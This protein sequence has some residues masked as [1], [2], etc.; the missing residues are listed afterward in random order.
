MLTLTLAWRNLFR[1]GRRTLLTVLLIGCSLAAM[2]MT[3]A[4]IIGMSNVLVDSV[5]HTLLGEAQVDRKG[6]RTS[7]DSSLYLN[8]ASHIEQV[9]A[10]SP[11][12]AAWA[13]RVITGGMVSSSY[14]IASGMIYGV[15]ARKELAVSRIKN[16]IVKGKYLS[17]KPGQILL[18][19][20]L[21]RQLEV[22]LGD[23]IVLTVSQ[24]E[25]GDLS[26]ALFR[27]SGLVHF[28]TREFDDHFVFINL[29]KARDIL[30]MHD[31]LQ[32]IAIQ[33]KRAADA[34]N[35]NLPLF[36]KLNHGDVEAV[37]WLEIN[38]GIASVLGWT[39]YSSAIVAVVL[40]LL[41]SFGV[42]N[43]MFMSI[44]ERIYEIGVIKSIGTRPWQILQLILTEAALLALLGAAFGVALGWG[45]GSWFS[46]H[47]IPFGEYELSG[48]M[49]SNNIRPVLKPYQF[50]DFPLYVIL[51]TI[52]AAIYPAR[53]A[54]KIVPAEALQRSL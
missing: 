46:I 29:A 22:K 14:N 19:D 30:G 42:I 28:G 13:P 20:G 10:A 52:I 32:Q 47:G 2:I 25:S 50:I 27:V 36:R 8:G 49:L 33:F 26:Q 51:L 23:R 37:N 35:P 9:I 48:V 18:G 53:F 5:T 43:S 3:D 40:F 16:A 6:F 38:P 45:L 24:P 1:N 12:V 17:G 11:S 44:Y 21:A 39:R 41:A 15:D 54:S 31:Q 7:F 34:R 4:I